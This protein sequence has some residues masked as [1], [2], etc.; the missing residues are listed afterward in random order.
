MSHVIATDP[1]AAAAVVGTLVMLA[2]IGVAIYQNV[3][4]K[5]EFARQLTAQ[6]VQLAR[7]VEES[8]RLFAR[9]INSGIA[10]D[11]TNGELRHSLESTQ[12]AW[13][14]LIYEH[15]AVSKVQE[16]AQRQAGEAR[17]LEGVAEA[18]TALA[19]EVNN[20]LTALLVNVEFLEAGDADQ[21]T[22]IAEIQAAA[23]RIAGVV[24]RLASVAN[25]RSVAY[26]G[27]SRMLDLSPE[28]PD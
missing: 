10:L 17:W 27:E 19:H 14:E 9:L 3:Q 6:S 2:L 20:P 15:A 4:S 16:V 12:T 8:Q 11:Q 28:E 21:A 24:K 13:R 25:A 7:Q 22:E 5:A 1:L 26:L 23:L 18:T